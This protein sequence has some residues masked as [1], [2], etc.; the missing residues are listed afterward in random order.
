MGII[1]L[2]YS[3]LNPVWILVCIALCALG[4]GCTY[5]ERIIRDGW[6]PL[7]EMGISGGTNPSNPT[8][9]AAPKTTHSTDKW[10]ILIQSME[11]PGHYAQAQQLIQRLGTEAHL[12]NLWLQNRANQTHIFRGLYANPSDPAARSDLRQTRMIKLADKRS[13]TSAQLVPLGAASQGAVDAL[14]LRR[15]PGVYSLQIGYYD[16]AFGP[17]FR[18]AAEQAARALREQ[19]DAEA[20]YYHGQHRSMVTIGL[21]TDEDFEQQGVQRV[22]GRHIRALQ[23]KYPFNLGNGRT[24]IQS[25]G[26]KDAGEQS[27]FL[28]RVR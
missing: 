3:Y 7:R 5:E 9:P 20:Y 12:P 1:S 23:E 26:G 8:A 16:D 24:I 13:F 14:D 15:H 4:A 2:R 19:D 10:A 17:D 28:V 27:S 25:V 6:A 18:K 11:G 21:F 22:Y